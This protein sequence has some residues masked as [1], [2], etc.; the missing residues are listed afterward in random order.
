MTTGDQSR[1][2]GRPSP[3]DR[4][5]SNRPARCPQPL[6]GHAHDVVDGRVGLEGHVGVPLDE[7]C[8]RCARS[9]SGFPTSTSECSASVARNASRQSC[10]R[11][12]RHH[13]YIITGS[14]GQ[15]VG[16]GQQAILR[17]R[18]P[19]SRIA[20]QSLLPPAHRIDVAVDQ[21]LDAGVACHDD[22]GVRLGVETGFGHQHHREDVARGGAQSLS[23]TRRPARIGQ[24]LD[25]RYRR[26]NANEA[27][28]V[29]RGRTIEKRNITC[30]PVAGNPST[31]SG[32]AGETTNIDLVV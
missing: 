5:G 29:M 11:L 3:T 1:R 22:L 9:R 24:G 8:P 30:R 25:G 31:N 28:A 17:C 20:S 4:W 14:P 21:H 2:D 32:R 16:L 19:C 13:G 10:G 12:A 26:E 7:P 6:I 18:G 23:A 15:R 27:G